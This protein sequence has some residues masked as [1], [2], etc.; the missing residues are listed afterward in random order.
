MGGKQMRKMQSAALIPALGLMVL[1]ITGTA[2]TAGGATL[3]VLDEEGGEMQVAEGAVVVWGTTLG[4]QP[5]SYV[6]EE[7]QPAPTHAPTAAATAAVCTLTVR[8]IWLNG[9]SVFEG[10]TLQVCTGNFGTHFTKAQVIRS[11]WRGWLGYSPWMYSG[12]EDGSWLNRRWRSPCHWGSGYYDY[13]WLAQG[14]AS[15]I[16]WGPKVVSA[17]SLKHQP[18]GSHS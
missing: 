9:T 15:R 4:G 10:E 18:C 17:N 6:Q 5:F 14:Y 12:L 8:N 1:F 2:F 3:T 16:G 13:K 11:S 7:G